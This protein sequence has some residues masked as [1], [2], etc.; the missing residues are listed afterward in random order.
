VEWPDLDRYTSWTEIAQWIGDQNEA[1]CVVNLKK[2]ALRLFGELRENGI[3]G[4]SHLSTSMCPAHRQAV[5]K[6]IRGRLERKEPCRLIST[7]CVEAGVDLDFPIVYR[8]FGPLDAIAQAAGRCNRNGLAPMG[9]VQ[10]F[11]PE[12]ERYPDGT[13]QQAASVTRMLLKRC[14]AQLMD[15]HNPELFNEYF[16]ELYSV[17]KPENKKPELIE[18]IKR[19]DFVRVAELYRV[20]EKDALNVLVPYDLDIFRQLEEEVRQTGLNRKWIAKARPYTIGLFRPKRHTPIST[21][22]VPVP[23]SRGES[24]EDW[25]L[26]TKPE[27]YHPDMGLVP[28]EG[29]ECLIG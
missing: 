19:Q 23:L 12:E 25:F 18:A 26:Y 14:G 21:Y 27:H 7:Q 5:L 15:I 10:V 20:I 9:T 22:L 4:L 11:L 29:M 2:H 17:A 16:R 24:A 3:E 1:L 28:P 8:A 6:E 13:Y